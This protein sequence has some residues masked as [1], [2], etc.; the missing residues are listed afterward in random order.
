MVIFLIIGYYVYN[1]SSFANIQNLKQGKASTILIWNIVSLFVQLLIAAIIIKLNFDFYLIALA[2]AIGLII[3]SIGVLI[4]AYSLSHLK[5]NFFQHYIKII[6]SILL[7]IFSIYLY[8]FYIS[9]VET[10]TD[11]IKAFFVGLV[12][13]FLTGLLGVKSFK[14]Y[15]KLIS[16]QTYINGNR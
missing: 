13:C 5:A 9:D 7:I 16:E 3:S 1:I 15:L 2:P 14:G 11:F 8:W 4:T 6:I 12:L 10:L